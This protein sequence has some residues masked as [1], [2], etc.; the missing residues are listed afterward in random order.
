LGPLG[1]VGRMIVEAVVGQFL[2]PASQPF[3]QMSSSAACH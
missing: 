1:I 2:H 3:G